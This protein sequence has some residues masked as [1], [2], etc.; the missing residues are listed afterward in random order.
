M[1][2]RCWERMR[3]LIPIEQ[4]AY[5]PGRSTTEQVFCIKTLSEKAITT[6]NFTIFI[7][8]LDM[9]KAFDSIERGKLMEY[10]REVLNNDEM[11]MLHLLINDVRINVEMGEE[12]SE[13]IVTNIGSCQ[14]DCLSAIFFIIYLAKSIKPLPQFI[15]RQDYERPLWSD[16]DW[17]IDRDLNKIEIDP[18]YSDDI[19]FIRSDYSKIKQLKR[20]VPNLLK[21]N[22]LEINTS[23]TEE[24]IINNSGNDDKWKKCKVLGSLIDTKADIDR[25]HSLANSSYKKFEKIFQSR[26]SIRTKIRAFESFV[27]SIFLY[28]CGLWTTTKE[29][30]EKIDVIQRRF[31]RRILKVRWPKKMT[32]EKIYEITK[33]IPWSELVRKRALNWLGHLMRLDKRTPARRALQEYTNKGKRPQKRPKETWVSMI[34]KSLKNSELNLNFKNDV[35]LFSHLEHICEDRKNWRK[36][37]KNTKL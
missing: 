16:L 6:D 31:L 10:L 12:R 15:D 20:L 3:T 18:K 2:E 17:L 23:K 35:E 9:S 30:N 4:A 27:A 22:N 21:E 19:N 7:L 32:N 28:N 34:K 26:I 36:F 13:D 37:V 24:Y 29:I 14:G 25:R 8:M 1:I 33:Q 11:Y 5:Q